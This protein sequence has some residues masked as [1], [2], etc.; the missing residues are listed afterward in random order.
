MT[1]ERPARILIQCRLGSSRLPGKALLPVGGV[2]AAVLCAQ[3]AGNLGRQV[4]VAIPEGVDD[5]ILASMLS[6]HGIPF[7]RGALEDVL[8]RFVDATADLPDHACVVR[9]TAD[10]LFPDG[11]FIERL[12][13]AFE[14][15]GA[16]Y[17]GTWSPVDGLPYGVSG[18]V[19]SVSILR[20]AA[21]Q[22]ADRFDRE[23]VTPWIIRECEPETPDLRTW[24]DGDLSHL[25]C[26]I[27][28]LDDYRCVEQLFSGVADPVRTG[29]RE[30]C[31]LLL[32]CT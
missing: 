29:W 31:G 5:E 4:L 7:M 18:E 26:T 22:A 9:L 12:L 20:K 17:F 14:R 16:T 32:R 1:M 2:P 6:R 10:N 15:S 25:R 13:E 24:C 11:E 8:G 30:L 27:D 28:N 19:F 21:T 23:H 3:R